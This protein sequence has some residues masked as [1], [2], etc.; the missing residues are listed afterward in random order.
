MPSPVMHVITNLTGNAGAETMLTRLLRISQDDKILVVPLIGVSERNRSLADNSRVVFVPLGMHSGI[1]MIGGIVKLAHLLSRE[2][3]RAIV[4]WMY[5]A[6]TIGTMA[7]SIALSTA[8]IFWNVRQSLDDPDSLSRSTRLALGLG[9][10]FSRTPSGIIY[11]SERALQLHGNYGYKNR[12][13]VVIPNGFDIPENVAVTAKTPR[14]FGIAGRFHPQ[15]DYNTFFQAAANV[16]RAFPEARFKA[17]GNG[18]SLEN[19]A[20]TKLLKD[21]GMPSGSIEL[22]GES[23]DMPAFY[24]SIDV[25]VLSSRTEGFPNVVAEAMSYGKPVITTDVGDAAAIVD[26]TGWVVPPRDVAS[27]ALAMEDALRMPPKKYA[28]YASRAKQRIADHY[29]LNTVCLQY[30]KFLACDQV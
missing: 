2:K 26:N 21:A 6:M 7:R 9:R 30:E 18:L 11:N 28:D 23:S 16:A 15:K 13:A 3:P 25:L 17:V 10:M 22:C 8:P 19:L 29:E 1:D 5:H 14:I 12:N 4:C 20:V 27:L 24:R